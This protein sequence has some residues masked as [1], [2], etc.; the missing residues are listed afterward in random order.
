LRVPESSFLLAQAFDQEVFPLVGLR[1]GPISCFAFL[2]VLRTVSSP[3]RP[4]SLGRCMARLSV[5]YNLARLSVLQHL[6]RDL[7]FLLG[8]K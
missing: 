5:F 3:V 4:L 8:V 6:G 2:A 1:T 7:D